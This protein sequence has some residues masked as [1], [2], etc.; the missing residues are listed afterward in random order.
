MKEKKKVD[1]REK[2]MS[3]LVG[4]KMMY[5]KMI[6]FFESVEWEEQRSTD[7]LN[8]SE[9][10]DINSEIARVLSMKERNN[11]K[12][13]PKFILACCV[14]ISRICSFLSLK[15]DTDRQGKRRRRS[16]R[17]DKSATGKKNNI[18]H[19]SLTHFLQ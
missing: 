7:D 14:S 4:T 9:K 15:K 18:Q 17:K 5:E 1:G 8:C 12:R 19:S 2:G 10:M 16:S 11:R 3:L 13:R 6:V